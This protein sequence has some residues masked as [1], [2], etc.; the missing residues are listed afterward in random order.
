MLSAPLVVCCDLSTLHLPHQANARALLT[1]AEII[2]IDQDPDVI[3]AT[4][5]NAGGQNAWGTD[6]WIKPLHNGDFAVAFINKD[7]S[8]RA[9]PLLLLTFLSAQLEAHSC[10]NDVVQQP[11]ISVNLCATVCCFQTT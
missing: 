2:A 9:S 6:V 7:S 3:M 5:I 8:A 1:N 10:D 11:H 4:R